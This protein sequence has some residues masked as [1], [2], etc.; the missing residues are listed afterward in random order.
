MEDYIWVDTKEDLQRA[1]A[2]ISSADSISLD[3]EYDS[4]R[5][6]RDKLCLIQIRA[7]D[8]TFLLDPLGDLDLSFLGP[9]FA[10]PEVKV[11]AHAG[12]ND[13]RL[14]KRDY[15][16][17]FANIFDTHR[18]ALIL[19]YEQLSLSRLV[20]HFLGVELDKKKKMQRSRWD[21][22]PLEEEQLKYAA[23]DVFYLEDLYRRLTELLGKQGLGRE[24]GEAFR[25]IVQVTWQERTLDTRGHLRIKG[26]Q[27]LSGSERT[28]LRKLFQ[29]RFQKARERNRSSFMILS[30]ET[31]LKLCRME[32][33]TLSSITSQGLL[34]RDKTRELG[35]EIIRLLSDRSEMDLTDDS[36]FSR[37]GAALAT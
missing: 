4:F 12:D 30:D 26:Y 20:G 10:N 14:L 18:A 8:S 2:T 13:I 16:F 17:T 25:Q 36:D 27:E 29:W 21:I 15:D 34:S 22:R 19:G 23:L 11:I 37:P 7:K 35:T 1:L 6:F 3:T 31:L 28:R 32:E 24:A 9:V 5:Y 33:V